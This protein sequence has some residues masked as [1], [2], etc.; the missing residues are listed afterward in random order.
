MF[1]LGIVGCALAEKSLYVGTHLLS[2]AHRATVISTGSKLRG[3]RRMPRYG[4]QGKLEKPIRDVKQVV[5]QV[6]KRPGVYSANYLLECG[7]LLRQEVAFLPD[8]PLEFRCEQCPDIV[9]KIEKVVVRGEEKEKKPWLSS[10]DCLILLWRGLKP[11][12][13]DGK[14]R[15]YKSIG[16]ELSLSSERVRQLYARAAKKLRAGPPKSE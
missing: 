14:Q 9:Y 10:R 7:H 6:R 1:L 15:T 12:T 5:I 3:R 2:I 11:E 8:L 13:D 4:P 16:G